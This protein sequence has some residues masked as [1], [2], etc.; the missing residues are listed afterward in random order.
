MARTTDA[1]VRA[2]ID[3]TTTLD[4][5]VFISMAN[6]LTTEICAPAAIG[7]SATRLELIERSLAAHFATLKEMRVRREKAGSVS[8][9]VDTHLNLGFNN[10][11]HGQ[12][13][14]RLDTNG[15][16]AALDQATVKGR[17]R[18]IGVS[19]LGVEDVDEIKELDIT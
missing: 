10:T 6:E 9:E 4:L 18:A 17:R 1:N 16:L 11:H 5:A 12:A 8:E 15:G 19:Y 3:V 13:A 2:I 14:M 7:Y